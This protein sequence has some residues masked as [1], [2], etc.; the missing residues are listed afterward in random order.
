M[1]MRAT[2]LS[3][4]STA[5]TPASPQLALLRVLH[6]QTA[7]LRETLGEAGLERWRALPRHRGLN[8]VHLEGE[9]RPVVLMH[10]YG[11]GL[12]LFFPTM[13]RIQEL[14]RP[15]PVYAVDWFGCGAS[16]RPADGA[17]PLLSP[18]A[19][20]PSKRSAAVAR[21]VSFFTDSLAGWFDDVLGRDERVTLV[22]HS[23]GGYLV[24]RFALSHPGRVARLFLA[25]PA[26]VPAASDG[27]RRSRLSLALLDALWAANVTPQRIVRA[28]GEARGRE[29]VRRA[30]AGR[31]RADL[32]KSRATLLTAD[33]LHALASA[34]PSGEF[35]LN[36]I[37][38]PPFRAGGVTAREPLVGVMPADR[39]ARPFSVDVAF[40]D[41]DWL[42]T[43]A[44]LEAARRFADDVVVF[45]RAGHHL[46]MDSPDA[47]TEFAL[48]S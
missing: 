37:L 5:A 16:D 46:Y 40:G 33:Y 13:R 26:G 27:A 48:R 11:S 19:C 2:A 15:P 9:G 32:T 41:R 1:A 7:L 12:A 44:A 20:S 18:A 42:G 24:S 28:M 36:S 30:V 35:A 45:G 17:S 38:A 34:P 22:G 21:A 10:G 47:F 29:M 3:R 25:S 43:P 8:A 23:L 4:V 39:A 6:A 14:A 31:F